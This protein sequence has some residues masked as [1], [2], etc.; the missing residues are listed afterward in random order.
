MQVQPAQQWLIEVPAK[1]INK[2]VR[3]QWQD[4]TS[5]CEA[6]KGLVIP[7]TAAKLLGVHASRIGQLMGAGKL[8]EFDHFGHKWLSCAQ[9][10]QRLSEPRDKGGRPRKIAA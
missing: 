9:L 5:D 7:A 4:Y 8:S 1:A 3:Q 2:T 6:E 10:M